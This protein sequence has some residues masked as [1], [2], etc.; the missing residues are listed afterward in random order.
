MKKRKCCSAIHILLKSQLHEAKIKSQTP[1]TPMLKA[2]PAVKDKCLTWLSRSVEIA[3]GSAST[4]SAIVLGNGQRIIIG[5]NG[6]VQNLDVFRAQLNARMNSDL[7]EYL[8]FR[9]ADS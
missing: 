8:N 2:K 9:Q 5:A 7:D 1:T 4:S 6:I 3:F